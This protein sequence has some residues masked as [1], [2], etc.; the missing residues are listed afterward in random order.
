M[1]TCRIDV[2]YIKLLQKQIQGIS[3]HLIITLTGS[4]SI[5]DAKLFLKCNV[6]YDITMRPLNV[7]ESLIESQS[8]INSLQLF[9]YVNLILP[10]INCLFI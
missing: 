8:L 3:A 4:T 9:P 6:M 5:E 1:Y 2:N 7:N 10:K